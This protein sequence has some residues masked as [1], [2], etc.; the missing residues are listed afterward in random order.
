MNMRGTTEIS[1]L[2]GRKGLS[3]GKL[4]L[5][6]AEVANDA[7]AYGQVFSHTSGSDLSWGQSLSTGGMFTSLTTDQPVRTALNPD[8]CH[9]GGEVFPLTVG[10]ESSEIQIPRPLAL[11]GKLMTFPVTEPFAVPE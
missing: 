3:F 11:F 6:Y 9:T 2:R 7:F 1:G 5:S 10:E 4:R 8:P